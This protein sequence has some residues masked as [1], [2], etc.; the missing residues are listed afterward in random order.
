MARNGPDKN[1]GPP[2]NK[3]V[4]AFSADYDIQIAHSRRLARPVSAEV[5]VVARG[6]GRAG[7]KAGKMIHAAIK[8]AISGVVGSG[9]ACLVAQ[10]EV[11]AGSVLP[12]VQAAISAHTQAKTDNAGARAGQGVAA[13]AQ[14]LGG[15]VVAKVV[16]A[17]SFVGNKYPTAA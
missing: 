6:V 5:V 2:V 14:A 4:T 7:L 11:V 16:A 15:G 12:Q 10:K 3:R 13:Q 1:V 9:R 17:A 8:C